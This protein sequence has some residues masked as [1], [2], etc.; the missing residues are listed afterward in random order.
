MSGS[1]LYRKG[2]NEYLQAHAYGNATAEDF[3]NAMTR[4]TGKPVDKI[5]KSFIDQPG[6]PEITVRSTCSGGVTKVT[7][8]Q[9]RFYADREPDHPV[10]CRQRR[11]EWV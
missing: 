1:D 5:M 6:A 11:T 10:M 2:V 9:E 3:W 8:R 4:A 7:L